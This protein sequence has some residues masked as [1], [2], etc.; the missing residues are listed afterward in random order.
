MFGALV[1]PRCRKCFGVDL[2]HRTAS[3]PHCGRQVR[4]RR[5]KP[6][7]TSSSAS[8]TAR[9]VAEL[10]TRGGELHGCQDIDPDDTRPPTIGP[11]SL[12]D[13]VRALGEF[14]VSELERALKGTMDA[15]EALIRLISAG[16]VYERSPG[17]YRGV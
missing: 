15:E 5:M 16:L 3:C 1:C 11:D 7:F 8:L 14:D 6:R 17:R 12:T 10:N 9:A 2:E 13:L 4:T